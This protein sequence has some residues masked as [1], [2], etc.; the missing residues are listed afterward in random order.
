MIGK[1][2]DPTYKRK[3]IFLPASLLVIFL[4]LSLQSRAADAASSPPEPL[5]ITS[6]TP[7]EPRIVFDPSE[8]SASAGNRVTITARVLDKDGK[9]VTPTTPANW[10]WKVADPNLNEFVMIDDSNGNEATIVGLFGNSKSGAAR[11]NLIPIIVT[12]SGTPKVTGVVNVRLEDTPLARGPIPPGIEPQ[13]DIMWAVMP[14]NV[15][16]DNFGSKIKK[17]YYGIEVVIGNDSGYDLE[18]ASVGFDLGA[19]ERPPTG[20]SSTRIPTSGY[21]VARASLQRRQQLSLRNM[22]LNI[23]KALGPVLTGFTPFFHNVNHTNN[24]VEG[25]NILS[26]PVEKGFELVWPDL[27]LGQLANLEDQSLRDNAITRTVVKNNTQVRFVVFVPKNLINYSKEDKWW[28]DHPLEVM[29][30]LGRMILVG[31]QVEHINRVRVV[32][33][34]ETGAAFSIS[35]RVTDPCSEG[36]EGATVTLNQ[37]GGFSS[38]D[39]TDEDGNYK[40]DNVPSGLTYTVTASKT[41]TTFS[42]TSGTNFTLH[43][44]RS[45][46]DFST[47]QASFTVK[48]QVTKSEDDATSLTDITIKLSS[49]SVTPNF[50]RTV[51]PNEDGTY[52][53][54]NVPGGTTYRV[55]PTLNDRT[56]NP[57]QPLTVPTLNCGDEEREFNFAL[58]PQEEPE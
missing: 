15:T 6:P 7:P 43:G 14:Q 45:N 20:L 23:L 32:S 56:F 48:G 51:H 3:S 50:E 22:T 9:T 10:D 31:D 17:Q 30:R 58:E 1:H 44:N 38:T 26:S 28:R 41:D 19:A 47:T 54:P 33:S 29:K 16:H 13:V 11:P 57:N 35:G 42:S 52:E 21:R 24:F 18:L 55:T 2:F 5:P 36:V 12:F 39:T 25:I 53:F 4:V 46:V 40:F 8:P 34:A 27:T 49:N 37:A